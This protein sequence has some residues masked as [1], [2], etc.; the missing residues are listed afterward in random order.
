MTGAETLGL[1]VG[2]SVLI[3]IDLLGVSVIYRIWIGDIDLSRLLSE[4][5]GD[6][7][8]SRFQLL[9]F[10]YV[11]ALALFLIAVRDNQFPEISG[12]ILSLL[13][14]SASTYAVSKG[15]Q[16][17]ADEG[18]TE[19]PPVIA[20]QPSEIT[21]G[22]S[23][24]QQFTATIRRTPHQDV[25]WSIDPQLGTIDPDSGAYTAPAVISQN[26]T[27][28]V[29]AVSVSNASVFDSAIVHLVVAESR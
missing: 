27:V 11:I 25:K 23:G 10:T 20:V 16:F 3:L 12:G 21:L 14:I 17:S 28:A 9:V 13:G 22:P 4:P 24:R 1:V 29:R 15:I 6:A 26:A 2:W 7:S 8:I 5:T 19:R 18:V